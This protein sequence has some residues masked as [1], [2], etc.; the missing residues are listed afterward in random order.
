MA[1]FGKFTEEQRAALVRIAIADKNGFG[2]L[3]GSVLPVML[4]FKAEHK[5]TM[6]LREIAER[7]QER[8]PAVKESGEPRDP[9]K[10]Q[11]YAVYGWLNALKQK[12]GRKSETPVPVIA[13]AASMLRDAAKSAT[14][15]VAKSSSK[16]A[17]KAALANVSFDGQ[18]A[19]SLA[20]ELI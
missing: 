15:E 1:L 2:F 11:D 8:W 17:I 20:S 19:A 14:P 10:V 4:A 9:A 12:Y 3:V 13:S 18:V 16:G 7:F 5:R 6:N